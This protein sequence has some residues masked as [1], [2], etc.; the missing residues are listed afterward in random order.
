M[1]ELKM[2]LVSEQEIVHLPEPCLRPGRFR[3]LR[4]NERMWVDFFK[5]KVAEYEA[6]AGSEALEQKCDR[7]RGLFAVRALEIAIFDDRDCRVI[8]ATNMIRHSHRIQQ[9]VSSH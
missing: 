1:R 6:Y 8:G 3:G 2:R 4:R 7:G 9:S 5:W